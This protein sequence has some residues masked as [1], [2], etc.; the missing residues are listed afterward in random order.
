MRHVAFTLLLLCLPILITP[1]PTSAESNRPTRGGVLLIADTLEA[2]T[3]DPAMAPD[4]KSYRVLNCVCEGLVAMDE[5]TSIIPSL[6]LSWEQSDEGRRWTFILRR[7]VRF[8]DGDICD[9][10]AVAY[11]LRRLIDPTHPQYR[12][13]F[14]LADTL[15]NEVEEIQPL[16]DYRLRITLR[17]AFAPFLANLT[18]TTAL[19]LSPRALKTH[20]Q[21]I[22]K[23]PVGTGP[24]IFD[25][26]T[27]GESVILKANPDYWNDPPLLDGLVF[28]AIPSNT[29]RFD[30]FRQGLVDAML[31]VP[32][33]DVTRIRQLS[34]A[35]VLEQPGL[36]IAY[37]GMNTS[38]PPLD[39]K[40]VRQAIRH[41]IPKQRLVKLF[42][43]G[44]ASI[45]NSPLS[46]SFQGRD[47]SPDPYDYNPQKARELLRQAGYPKGF[48]TQLW[49]REELGFIVPTPVRLAEAIKANLA[50]VGIEA[51][52]K[53]FKGKIYKRL[54]QHGAHG[55]FLW[56]WISTVPDPDN[57][58]YSL[59]SS[60]NARSPS[61]QNLSFFSSPRLDHILLDARKTYDQKLRTD[62]YSQALALIREESPWLPLAHVRQMLAL[63]PGVHGVVQLPTDILCFHKAWLEP[64][65]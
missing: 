18:H 30:T 44:Q 16:D 54:L 50:E 65:D 6:A 36:N 32:P 38:L 57:V 21:D 23:H 63:R 42:Y 33:V 13:D 58:L 19:I 60:A 25:A 46:P 47:D 53:V 26:W 24:F 4:I 29:L 2:Q 41:A 55:L 59:L 11:S 61:P 56:G 8:H 48:Q 5:Q 62:L 10:R 14:P 49:T 34:G 7:N 22:D 35:L 15:F 37:M 28:K 9:A 17:T 43:Q 51:R 27:P 12:D 20:G 40:R 3:L 52:I 39:D 31:S 64:R 1:G 45:A